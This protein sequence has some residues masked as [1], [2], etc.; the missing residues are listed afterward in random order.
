MATA[1]APY[2]PV[3]VGADIG[4]ATTSIAKPDG[5]V[6][7]FPSAFTWMGVRP[8]DGLSKI[9]TSL[10]HIT[11]NGRNYIVGNEALD[12]PGV[13]TLLAE[14]GAEAHKRYL[15]DVSLLCFL[16]GVSAAF[17]ATDTV[18][19]RL[20]TGAPLSIF[21][22]W[23]GEIAKRYKGSHEY[24]YNGHKRR[25]VVEEVQ[26]YGE[27]REA[28]RLLKADQR[29]GNVAVHD[30]GG[31]TWNVLLFKDGAL[32]TFRT[33]D[34]GTE[35]LLDNVRAVSKDPAARWAL[36]SEM[37]QNPKAHAAI[38]AEIEREVDAALG[39]IE[40]KVAL[41]K[42]DRHA[43]IGGGATYLGTPLKA[44][45]NAPSTLLNGKAPEG[46]NALAYALAASE[47]Q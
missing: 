18:G 10:H 37:R 31:K 45:Y 19:V 5:V 12:M 43:L 40:R 28:L 2:E 33:F 25:V 22:A 46:A 9:A 17:P 32:K 27:G 7:F 13:D 38:R 35:R 44:R 6:S 26:V 14:S 42:A 36:Q 15:E 47:V 1:R 4:N 20:A 3:I 11:Y 30:L 24:T 23:G 8:Y 39:V 16:A 21:E 41:P 34:L 29:G